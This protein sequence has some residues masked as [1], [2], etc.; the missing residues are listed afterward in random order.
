VELLLIGYELLPREIGGVMIAETRLPR[1]RGERRPMATTQLPVDES[2]PLLRATEDVRARVDGVVEHPQDV[3]RAGFVPA[4]L[5]V[6]IARRQLKAVPQ[7]VAGDAV[8]G[9]VEA[10][11]F[12]HEANRALHLLVGVEA[13]PTRG[14]VPFVARG[15]RQEELASARLVEP[16]AGIVRREV[17]R[18]V[19]S[20]RGQ[21]SPL[22]FA[23]AA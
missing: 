1:V 14:R 3:S 12:E 23:R 9:A 20:R 6:R 16:P 13:K 21:T 17:R 5:T 11:P 15:R 7:E 18:S 22:P 8:G 2:E 19:Q 4:K 10:K